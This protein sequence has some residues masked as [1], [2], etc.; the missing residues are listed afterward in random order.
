M[1]ILLTP[2]PNGRPMPLSCAEGRYSF[3]AQ[4]WTL[5]NSARFFKQIWKVGKVGKEGK[6]GKVGKVGNVGKVGKVGKVGMVGKV[7]K[8]GKEGKEGRLRE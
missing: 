8:V 3:G 4:L 7:G 6:V 2:P 5:N 1:S